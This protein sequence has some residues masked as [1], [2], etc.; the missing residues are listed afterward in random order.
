M[1]RLKFINFFFEFSIPF[2]YSLLVH[3]F[4]STYTTGTG[5]Y[6]KMTYLAS[7]SDEQ[8][9][10][11]RA[12]DDD[13]ELMMVRWQEERRAKVACTHVIAD[14][15]F[16]PSGISGKSLQRS[17]MPGHTTMTCFAFLICY[18]PGKPYQKGISYAIPDPLA[19]GVR[20]SITPAIK[21]D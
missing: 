19:I 2:V 6:Y 3:V 15:K 18:Y 8:L 10:L 12:Y 14:G 9:E 16:Q 17:E 11:W 21:C 1:H 20:S 4:Y 7:D 5:D 13:S